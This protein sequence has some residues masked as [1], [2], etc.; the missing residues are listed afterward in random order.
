MKPT[1]LAVLA[2]KLEA[3]LRPHFPTAFADPR[4][5]RIRVGY[6]SFHTRAPCLSRVEAE[7]YLARLEA[8]YTEQY[9]QE[10]AEQLKAERPP[11]AVVY[12]VPAG[13][14]RIRDLP[15]WLN[16][17]GQLRAKTGKLPAALGGNYT[18]HPDDAPQTHQD[19]LLA[20]LRDEEQRERVLENQL[21]E[22]RTRSAR[23]RVLL[24]PL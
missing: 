18:V 19:A 12:Y 17:H 8:G 16:K 9:T 1:P 10:M 6:T 11:D 20:A 24:T 22:S 7:D 13:S 23:L 5:S 2:K 14:T 15:V 21:G 3:A 4:G